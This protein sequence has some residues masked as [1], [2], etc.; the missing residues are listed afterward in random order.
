M[1]LVKQMELEELVEQAMKYAPRAALQEPSEQE[2]LPLELEDAQVTPL[3]DGELAA[4]ELEETEEAPEGNT[5]RE[6][7]LAATRPV[8]GGAPQFL[9]VP[10]SAVPCPNPMCKARELEDCKPVGDLVALTAS[11]AA[12]IERWQAVLNAVSA[13]QLQ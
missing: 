5:I 13:G 6:G 3:T 4:L 9:Q 12:H 11:S 7:E 2:E 8:A 1:E 10:V